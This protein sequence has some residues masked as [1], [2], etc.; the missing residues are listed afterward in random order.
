MIP[1]GLVPRLPATNRRGL[2]KITA[3]PTATTAA[4]SQS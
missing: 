3:T 4:P 2:K 1:N